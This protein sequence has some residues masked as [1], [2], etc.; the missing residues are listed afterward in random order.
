MKKALFEDFCNVIKTKN[1]AKFVIWGASVKGM[2]LLNWLVKIDAG[3]RVI[4]FVDGNKRLQGKKIKGIEIKDPQEITFDRDDIVVLIASSAVTSIEEEIRNTS[5]TVAYEDMTRFCVPPIIEDTFGIYGKDKY[6]AI[7]GYKKNYDVEINYLRQFHIEINDVFCPEDAV[8]TNKEN[9]IFVI[10]DQEHLAIEKVL[11]NGGLHQNTDF[12]VISEVFFDHYNYVRS[13]TVLNA[14]DDRPA[15]TKGWS[16][17]FCPLP[18]TQ[19]YYYEDRADICSPSWNNNINVGSPQERSIE[20]IWNS[21][22]AKEIRR[23]VLDG[24]FKY[25]NEEMCWRISEGKLFRKSDIEDAKYR[26]IIDEG[27]TEIEGGPEFLNIGYNPICN[28][29]C[30]MC[31][32]GAFGIDED[33]KNRSIKNLKEYNFRNL[34][35]L[36]IPGNG[37]LFANKD[38]LDILLHID[39]YHFPVLEAIW[40][41]SNGVLFNEDNWNKISFLAERYKIKIFISTDSVCRETFMRIRRGGDYDQFLKNLKMLSRKRREGRFDKLYLPFCVQR[42]NFREME[43]FVA[44]AK[45]IGAD[46]V[47]FEKLFN[48]SVSECVHRPENVYYEEFLGH[49]EKAIDTGKR[50][51]IETEVKPFVKLLGSV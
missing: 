7:V 47:H 23:S 27:I 45:D 3:N 43:D 41:Y 8:N 39:E 24:S 49:L 4:C 22:K 32:H 15:E 21:E 29:H 31:R 20:E 12:V 44:F 34:K 10:V 25:C 9:T 50:I 17:L 6:Y 16:D 5:Q 38:Y 26:K 37:E 11:I 28:L 1:D 2:L 46:C 42:M 14:F 19:L 36:I 18:F 40:I 13:D 35:R 33:V 51:G 30:R 48:S